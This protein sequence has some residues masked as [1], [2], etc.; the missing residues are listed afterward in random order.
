MSEPAFEEVPHQ[1]EDFIGVVIKNAVINGWVCIIR[2]TEKVYVEDEALRVSMQTPL[3]DVDPHLRAAH[4][5]FVLRIEEEL[6]LADAR[7]DLRTES[8]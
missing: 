5:G 1:A 8:R 3:R 6:V 4:R 7:N 2:K